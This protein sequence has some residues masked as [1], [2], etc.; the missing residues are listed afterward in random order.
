M[1][2]ILLEGLFGVPWSIV[3]LLAV[4]AVGLLLIRA[5][6][7]LVKVA[8]VVGIGIAIYLLVQFVLKNFGA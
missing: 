7:T 3:L 4:V 5:A 2:A 1:D 8:I 6:I